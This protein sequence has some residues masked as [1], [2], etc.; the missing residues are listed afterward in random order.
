MK[1]RTPFATRW[2]SS[3]MAAPL[4]A[5]LACS[6]NDNNGGGGSG[7]G[8]GGGDATVATAAG[9][10]LQALLD[11]ENVCQGTPYGTENEAWRSRVRDWYVKAFTAPGVAVMPQ[12]IGAC[13]ARL[14]RP[15]CTFDD[16]RDFPECNFRVMPGTLANGS[17]CTSALTN[18][19]QSGFC[20]RG[21]TVGDECG[22][23]TALTP[24]G[25]QCGTNGA[26]PCGL[27]SHCVV[28]P[29]DGAA[30]CQSTPPRG[31]VGAS[32]SSNECK[33]EL[34]CDTASVTCQV[35]AHQDEACLHDSDCE[36]PALRCDASTEP[37]KCVARS[38]ENA[39]CAA[40]INDGCAEQLACDSKT[41]KCVKKSLANPGEPCEQGIVICRVGS[42]S[43]TTGTCPQVLPDGAA[44]D[45]ANRAQTCDV[46]ATC[47]QDKCRP[48]DPAQCK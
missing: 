36:R 24:N 35:P 10:L 3:L 45:S 4:M 25:G 27:Q 43:G 18:P 29:A 30:T 14:R 46:A 40:G 34:R 12:M 39:P 37:H 47:V 44:C 5:T 32:C 38:G 19:C 17:A 1:N 9:D 48:S 20:K 31:D 16:T 7:D 15:D 8:G 6:S 11:W 23:C 13:I 22:I 33:S 42:C 41:A 28:N 26:A 21:G 2:V